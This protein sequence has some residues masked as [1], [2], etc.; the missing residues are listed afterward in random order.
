MAQLKG[1]RVFWRPSAGTGT[2]PVQILKNSGYISV[3]LQ[4]V[5]YK[6]DGNFW[7]STFGG[8]DKITVS[9]QVTWQNLSNPI[10]AAAIQD[11]RKISVPSVNALAIGRNIVL[12]V[13]ASADGIELQVNIH[14]VHDDNLGKTLQLLNSDDFK[15]PLQLAPVAVGEIL[16]IANMVKKTFTDVED[17]ALTATYPGIVSADPMTDPVGASRIVQGY[18]IVVLKQDNE[19]QLDFDESK[20][21]VTGNRLVFNGQPVGNTYMVYNVTFD[22][23]RGADPSSPASKKFSEASTKADELMFATDDQ[24]QG[25]IASAH[26]FLMQGK[27]LLDADDT[28]RDEEKALLASAAFQVVADKIKANTGAGAPQPPSHPGRLRDSSALLLDLIEQSPEDRQS[29]S[30]YLSDLSRTGLHLGFNLDARSMPM[31]ARA[32]TEQRLAPRV[33]RIASGEAACEPQLFSQVTPEKW[34]RLVT[35]AAENGLTIGGNEGQASRDNYT[36][37]WKYDPA[38]QQLTLWC[39][40]KPFFAPCSAINE[41]IH[42]IVD[43][44]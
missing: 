27:G 9:T 18:I 20:L 23:W 8:S 43:N 30:G 34:Q 39:V 16:S 4:A 1:T 33:E 5:Q 7:Q 22:K 19:D 2:E 17:D 28:Y 31:P 37:A 11:V 42:K 29:V 26:D 15:K 32:N 24:R 3:T 41:E 36:F 12:K 14:A 21:S 25:I 40:K 6:A 13:P 35:K 44:A 10:T 38:A